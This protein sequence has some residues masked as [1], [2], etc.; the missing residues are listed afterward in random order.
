EGLRD[1]WV[2]NRNPPE[3]TRLRKLLHRM[4]APSHVAGLRTRIQDLTDTCLD[5]VA[6]RDRIDVVGDLSRPVSFA[7]AADLLGI[8]S[9]ARPPLESC[10]DH[11]T[12][13]IDLEPTGR[14]CHRARLGMIGLTQN[15][16]RLVTTWDR[17][18]TLPTLIGILLQAQD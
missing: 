15:F 11:S 18:G 8:P 16:R 7:V 3:H 6:G 14:A 17:A 13:I 10:A 9:E 12:S 4:F 1:L 2:V 5:R